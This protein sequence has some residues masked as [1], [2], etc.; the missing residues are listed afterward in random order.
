MYLFK[1]DIFKIYS[2]ISNFSI[3]RGRPIFIFPLY[4][5]LFDQVA[6]CR[7]GVKGNERG[8]NKVQI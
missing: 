6:D 1:R 2:R 3:Y 8:E 5:V 4:G 7:K